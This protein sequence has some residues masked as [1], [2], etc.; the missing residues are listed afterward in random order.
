ME[1]NSRYNQGKTEAMFMEKDSK[2]FRPPVIR[3][4]YGGQAIALSDNLKYL[5]LRA[6]VRQEDER[7]QIKSVRAKTA[8]LANNIKNVSK[9]TYGR[10]SVFIKRIVDSVVKSDV[11]YGSEIWGARENNSANRKLLLAAQRPF[12]R[13][14]VKSYSTTPTSGLW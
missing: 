11:L 5:L 7:A 1:S 2:V 9:R 13:A 3:L 12:L 4:E 8:E 10:K 6:T 14:T